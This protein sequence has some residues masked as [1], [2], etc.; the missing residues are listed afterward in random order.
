MTR[1]ARTV[2]AALDASGAQ[3][4]VLDTAAAL[5]GLLNA[6]VEAVHV[7]EERDAPARTDA[8]FAGVQVTLLHAGEVAAVLADRARQSDAVAVVLGAHAD[9]QTMR[10][11]GHVALQLITQLEKPVVVSPR[12]AHGRRAICR[13]LVPL[14]GARETAEA[15]GRVIETA[16]GAG[17][18]VTLLHVHELSALPLFTEQPQHERPAW[19]REFII[20]SRLHPDQVGLE[21]RVGEPGQHLLDVAD[22]SDAD[23]IIVGWGQDL[24]EGHAAVVREVLSAGRIPVMLLPV[25]SARQTDGAAT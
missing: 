17:V 11:A 15:L 12:G 1:P 20:R 7:P 21:V 3:G 22:R 18:E 13:M 5:A 10:P 14:D 23:M 2:I 24:S 19:S 9:P 4:S 25:A 6:E 8:A 16:I